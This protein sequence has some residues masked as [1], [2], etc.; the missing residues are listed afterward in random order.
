MR[1]KQEKE[2]SLMFYLGI[3]VSLKSHR[4]AILDNDGE[5]VGKSFSIDSSDEGFQNLINV[6]KERNI[7]INQLTVG[8]EATGHLWENLFNFLENNKIKTVLLN[9]F[10]TNRYRELLSKKAKTDDIDAYCIAGLLRSGEGRACYVPD[11][12]VQGLRDLVRTRN[13]FIK[14]LQDYQRQASTLLQV[15]F[16]EIFNIIKD[17]FGKVMSEVLKRYPTA[18][19]IALVKPRTLEK[20]AR[21]FQGNNFG[22]NKAEEIVAIAKKSIY[23]GRA[24]SARGKVM[25]SLIRQISDLKI[26]IAELDESISSSLNTPTQSTSE[27]DLITSIPGVGPKTAA[28]LI[29]EIGDVSRFQSANHLIG[30][31]GFFPQIRESGGRMLGAHRMSKRGPKHFR[32]AVY[33]ASVASLKHNKQLKALYD[34]KVSQGKAPKQALIVVARKLLATV[35]SLLRYQ[36]E[37]NPLR[38]AVAD[39]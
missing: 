37:Y 20:I 33:M 30:Y 6:L 34:R 38:L 26:A 16:P 2:R 14:N 10:Q 25:A 31:F 12:M 29:A 4:C 15:V 7:S 32:K 11:E 24:S 17:P 23:S 28:V 3:D 21:S 13:S 18:K 39:L 27:L 36:T 9:P 22:R 5:N 35:Y 8:M 19:N 1:R